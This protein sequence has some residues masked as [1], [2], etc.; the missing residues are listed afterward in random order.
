M[1]R[2]GVGAK[3]AAPNTSGAKAI[4]ISSDANGGDYFYGFGAMKD[5]VTALGYG[6]WRIQHEWVQ[7]RRSL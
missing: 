3:I 2:S 4:L 6:L 1:R 5:D 7:R